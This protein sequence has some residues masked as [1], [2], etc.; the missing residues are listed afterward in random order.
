MAFDENIF[1]DSVRCRPAMYIGG[2]NSVGLHHLVWQILE[3]FL[4]E[5]NGPICE[6]LRIEL[7]DDRTVSISMRFATESDQSSE[8]PLPADLA[9]VLNNRFERHVERRSPQENNTI[10]LACVC[11][12][13]ATFDFGTWNAGGRSSHRFLKGECVEQ[14]GIESSSALSKMEIRFQADA[15]MFD[16]DAK[17]CFF[18]LSGMIRD[19]AM[20]TPGID[21][22]LED[23]RSRLSTRCHYPAGLRDY[24][25]E[26]AS[27]QHQRVSDEPIALSLKTPAI[28]AYVGLLP[29]NRDIEVRSF[30]NRKWTPAGGVHVVGVMQ[31]LVAAIRRLESYDGIELSSTE[32]HLLATVEIDDIWQSLFCVIAIRHREPEFQGAMHERI[33]NPEITQRIREWISDQLL[34][35]LAVTKVDEDGQRSVVAHSLVMH[36]LWNLEERLDDA[37]ET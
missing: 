2:I 8:F 27:F 37:R 4:S 33:A 36:S 30:A 25:L 26:Y 17:L 20:Q 31:G 3:I 6:H 29:W 11:A 1:R 35:K 28:Q 24:I 21:I 10:Q 7:H 16:P 32:R 13:C 15:E 12:V 19:E 5:C 18:R 9:D 22:E 23:R 34:E 14:Q